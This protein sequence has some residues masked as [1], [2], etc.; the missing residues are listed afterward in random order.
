MS[1]IKPHASSFAVIIQ[2]IT[3]IKH[4]QLINLVTEFR[5][6]VGYQTIGT[7]TE[8]SATLLT[9]SDLNIC[10]YVLLLIF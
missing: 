6:C 8:I 4:L 10:A 7:I 3:I 1:V 5:D 2:Q 9:C